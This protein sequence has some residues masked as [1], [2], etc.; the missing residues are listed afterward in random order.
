VTKLLYSAIAYEFCFG[1]LDAEFCD[2]PP[3]YLPIFSNALIGNV[4]IADDLGLIFGHCFH[5]D[6]VRRPSAQS[7]KKILAKHLLRNEHVANF[8]SG[9][10]MYS[11]SQKTNQSQI[12]SPRGAFEI[13]Y[14]GLD[15]ILSKVD[16]EVFV[17]GIAATAGMLLPGSCVITI[18]SG[19]G[20]NRAFIPF[21]VSHPEVV[22]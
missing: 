19:S 20:P 3:K 17:N 10:Q 4:K 15:F 14:N 16:R 11:V 2:A 12:S 5:S 13:L 8:V 1:A 9:G 22:L 6:P 21:D 7:V 18:G